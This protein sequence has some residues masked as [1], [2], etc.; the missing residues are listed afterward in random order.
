LGAI[1]D[2]T[3]LP[4]PVR[5]AI[6]IWTHV[7][8]Q[9]VDEAP[10]PLAFVPALIHTVGA[11]YPATGIGSIPRA[12][13]D[14]AVSAGV[15]FEYGTK[16]VAIPS[17]QGRV[18][19]AE[20]DRG[21]FIAADAVLSNHSGVGTYLTLL[22]GTPRR[23][24]DRLNRL[25]LQSPGVCAYLAVR[26]PNRPPYLR[27]HL[28]EPGAACRLLVRP[29]VVAPA[30]E[31]GGWSPARL[32]APMPHREAE[33]GGLAGQQAYLDRILAERWWHESIEEY[34]IVATR[35]PAQWGAQ[36]ELYRDSMNP[37]MSARLMRA[38][39]LAHRS[40]YV[41][42]LYLA[43]SST[44]PGQWVSFCAIS[45]ILAADKVWEDLR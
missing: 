42:G 1:L 34:R 36:Y 41:R 13:A 12:L 37:V 19:G 30:V 14:A 11:Y 32:I 4:S 5:E 17:R 3:G 18:S 35:V 44:H 39:R 33:R 28:P 45:G 15:E 26:G 43:G 22:E 38:G 29:A 23:V 25:P 9:T 10:S 20:T 16:V 31:R 7:A 2:R 27:F 8:G 40:P 24:R 6:A 21:Q